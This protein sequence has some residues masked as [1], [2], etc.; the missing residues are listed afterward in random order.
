MKLWLHSQHQK[1]NSNAL[2]W[3]TAMRREW[4]DIVREKKREKDPCKSQDYSPIH[5]KWAWR[6]IQSDDFM[7]FSN[8]K[9]LIAAQIGFRKCHL[10]RN[11]RIKYGNA[12]IEWCV[13]C[14]KCRKTLC[15]RNNR[16]CVE[17]NTL[18][19]LRVVVVL[20]DFQFTKRF[21][22]VCSVSNAESSVWWFCY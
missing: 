18:L 4:M 9:L 14:E 1:I 19:S 2:I 8:R 6:N 3:W 13:Q 17:W 15:H 21:A 5:L 12:S 7:P 20:H 11:N 22:C 16:H 10:K